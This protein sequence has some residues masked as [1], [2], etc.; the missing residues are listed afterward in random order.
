M[1]ARTI[2]LVRPQLGDTV[3]IIGPGS[4]GLFHLQAFHAAGAGKIIMIGIDKDKRRFE[5][6][7][8][9]GATDIVNGSKE[10]V[11]PRVYE[12]TNGKGVDIAVETASASIATRL[13]IDV[14]GNRGRV[15]L[16]GL[17][18]EATVSPLKIVRSG[19]TVIGDVA[20]LDRHYLRAI[21]WVA[22]GSIRAE[23]LI[24]RRYKFQEFEEAFAASG[25]EETV[26]VMFEN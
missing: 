19:L 15:A 2:E 10:D 17:Y 16:F 25:L 21:R 11:V 23:A 20:Q 13:A 7:R 18:P 8:E 3:A 9:I 22:S 14:A 26:K 24:P 6:A 1:T 12:I 5:I 4:L